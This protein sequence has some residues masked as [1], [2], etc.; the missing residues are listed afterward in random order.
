MYV[1]IVTFM[2][3][4]L[5][6]MPEDWKYPII[7]WDLYSDKFFWLNTDVALHNAIISAWSLPA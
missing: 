5:I 4:Y 6:S 3:K 1:Q 7:K 2:L